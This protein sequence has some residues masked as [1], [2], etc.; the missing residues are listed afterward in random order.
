MESSV[1]D[2]L[3]AVLQ[4]LIDQRKEIQKQIDGN[5]LQIHEAECFAQEILDKDEEDF[6]VFS[7]RRYEDI[8]RTQLDE[9]YDRKS[10]L[11]NQ[12]KLW[13]E[14]RDR[15]DV[16]IHL[17]KSVSD[18]HKKTIVDEQDFAK[19][20][21]D[22]VLREK[23][24]AMEMQEVLKN[25]IANDLEQRILSHFQE[26]MQKI[27]LSKT[28]FTQDPMRAKLELSGLERS[29]EYAE[30]DLVNLIADLNAVDYNGLQLHELIEKALYRVDEKYRVESDLEVVSC[31]IRVIK[32]VLYQFF[33]KFCSEIQK[34]DGIEKIIVRGKKI[35]DN[36]EI[37][38]ACGKND[39]SGNESDDQDAS[40]FCVIDYHADGFMLGQLKGYISAMGGAVEAREQEIFISVKL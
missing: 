8:Y 1:Y 5:N 17:L 15:L 34:Y 6:T 3:N 4:D 32:I 7:P 11:E 21:K 18:D 38:L 9:S 39:L 29:I 40:D 23:L 10:A 22:D 37:H 2:E 35:K 33:C 19:E 20:S 25:R 24:N 12:N 28:F 14:K 36:Y 31:E 30:S 26:I 27:E 13:S 16:M